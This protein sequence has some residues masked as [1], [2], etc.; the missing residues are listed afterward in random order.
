MPDKGEFM[1]DKGEFMQYKV[2]L[3]MQDNGAGATLPWT[4]PMEPPFFSIVF[5]HFWTTGSPFYI[6]FLYY[7]TVFLF[8]F[9]LFLFTFFS[10]I[11]GRAVVLQ[12]PQYSFMAASFKVSIRLFV[13]RGGCFQLR[14][15][16]RCVLRVEN[17]HRV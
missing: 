10:I 2:P 14:S 9:S 13:K 8:I 7:I 12:P 6:F 17:Y 3:F 4:P 15:H 1:P 16:S 11:E 5:F